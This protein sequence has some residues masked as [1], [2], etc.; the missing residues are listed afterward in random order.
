MLA[1]DTASAYMRRMV[2][3]SVF[4]SGT[5]LFERDAA[6]ADIR[7]LELRR[8]FLQGV[9]A[10]RLLE[11]RELARER[12]ELVERDL[13]LDRDALDAHRPEPANQLAHRRAGLG[14]RQVA[15]DQL[16]AE[17]AD[18]DRGVVLVQ[19]AKRFGQPFEIARDD[20]V[21]GRVQLDAAQ[22][23][24]EAADQLVR[25]LSACRLRRS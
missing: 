21:G 14:H 9:A 1:T 8:G 16:V 12:L 22:R 20:R 13:A 4:S 6:D 7:R 24:A 3:A 10:E 11:L 23:R 5:L 15:D 18:D 19:G 25:Q 2:D 17:H